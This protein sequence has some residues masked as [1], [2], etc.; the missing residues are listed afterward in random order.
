MKRTVTAEIVYCGDLSATKWC[1]WAAPNSCQQK[2]TVD[3]YLNLH[4]KSYIACMFIV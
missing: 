4:I 1:I 3:R 2:P